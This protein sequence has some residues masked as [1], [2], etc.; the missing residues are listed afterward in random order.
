MN[1]LRK[2]YLELG[3]SY[4]ES[5]YFFDGSYGIGT[6]PLVTPV[7]PEK[8]YQD[9]L[10]D[11]LPESVET[12]VSLNDKYR[13][14]ILLDTHIVEVKRGDYLLNAIGQILNYARITGR[15]P[16][17][18]IF[19]KV[20]VDAI[21]TACSLNITVIRVDRCYIDTST[22]DK[23]SAK[24]KLVESFLQDTEWSQWSDR[25]IARQ[26][27]VSNR[28]VSNVRKELFSSRDQTR[29]DCPRKVRRGNNTY[30]LR[31]ALINRRSRF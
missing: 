28:Y 14:D 6:K 31:T 10:I 16:V 9:G 29:K 4:I 2:T 15:L 30:E 26:C 7:L 11:L 19:G 5:F 13:C 12:E 21:K 20:D 1:F 17:I 18:A 27:Q 23:K 24:R 25:A 8:C 3:S 22:D